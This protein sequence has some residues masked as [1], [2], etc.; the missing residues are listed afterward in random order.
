VLL[1]LFVA[2]RTV[3]SVERDTVGHLHIQNELRKTVRVIRV[4]LLESHVNIDAYLISPDHTEYKRLAIYEIS[5]ALLLMDEMKGRFHELLPQ[6]SGSVHELSSLL[7]RLKH[8]TEDLFLVR[9][10]HF[11]QFPSLAVGNQ[12]MRPNRDAFD[13]AILVMLNEIDEEGFDARDRAL[14]DQV[15]QVRH[16]WVRVLSDFRLYLANRMGTFDE[17]A[18]TVQEQAIST[19]YGELQ[20]ELNKLAVFDSKGKIGFQGSV[21]VEELFKSSEQ[22]FAGYQQVKIIHHSD[23]WRIDTNIMRDSIVPLIGEISNRL[24]NIESAISK[25][26]SEDV[27]TLSAVANR[28]I[29]IMLWA[30]ASL[31]LFIIVLFISTNRLVFAPI[32]TVVRAL[33]AE[34][35]GKE[36]VVLPQVRP[37]E[38]EALIE[39]FS[40]MSK[41]NHQ[42]QAALEHQA[43]HDGLTSL[44]NRMLLQERMA[45]YL[46]IARREQRAVSL[47]MIDLDR[48]KEI[49]DA[50]GHHVGDQVLVQV[51]LRLVGTLREFDTVARF[52]GDEFAALLPDC[53]AEDTILLCKK[54][55]MM[56]DEKLNIEGMVLPVSLSIGVSLFPQHGDDMTTLLRRADVAMYTAKQNKSG[57]AVYDQDSDEYSMGRLALI[58]DLTHAIENDQLMIHYQ[59]IISLK[60]NTIKGFEALL[61][62]RHPTHGFISPDQIINL[63]EQ[64]GLI[65]SLTHWI[66]AHTLE[67]VSL[68]LR[69]HRSLDVSINISV[70]ILKDADFVNKLESLLKQNKVPAEQVMLEI[71]ES[72]MMVNSAHTAEVLSKLDVLGLRVAVDDYGTGFSSLAYLKQ[73]PISELKIDKSFTIGM[74]DAGSDEVIV[75]STIEMAHRLGLQVVAEGVENKHILEKLQIFEC[76]TVQGYYL[77]PPLTMK[78]LQHWI[79]KN[80]SIAANFS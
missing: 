6:H 72:A 47:L 26:S 48:F 62:W 5:S 41:H 58:S 16:A 54:I 68:L 63:A 18:L 66:V 36:R 29:S 40:E 45:H 4:S 13:N 10:D 80:Y 44:P 20:R 21:A 35:S 43:L 32:A 22:W 55:L 52:G 75:H 53:N 79:D 78:D 7:S 70:H 17:N 3:K 14:F 39:A 31:I 30:A 24:S 33:K 8:R 38:T 59:P 27:V 11:R 71:T 28:T 64:T 46:Q 69:R 77:C 42:R 51:G 2:Y 67:Q 76:D 74:L 25:V 56:M 1:T 65:Q 49:N 12:I 57:Y 19:L 60:S 73:L 9:E 50:M 34:I 37:R 23:S 15:I 61:R